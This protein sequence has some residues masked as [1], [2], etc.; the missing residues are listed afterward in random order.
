MSRREEALVPVA[1]FADRALAEEAWGRLVD[2]GIPANV[3][4]DPAPLG[5]EPTTRVLVARRN[6]ESA[7]RLIADLVV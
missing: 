3:V 4:L 7:Q 5:G 1:E 6:A 2:E